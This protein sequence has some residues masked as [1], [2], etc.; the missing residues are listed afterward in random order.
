MQDLRKVVAAT[1]FSETS[2][3]AAL[4]AGMIAARHGVEGNLLHVIEPGLIE[5]LRSY[6]D[7]PPLLEKVREQAIALLQSL[8]E[9]VARETQGRLQPTFREGRVLDEVLAASGDGALL[10]LGSRGL[11][12]IH[13]YFL[14]STARNLLYRQSGPVLV[15]KGPARE[16][17]RNVL[18]ATDFSSH[19]AAALQRAHRLFPDARLQAVHVV[20]DMV[21][22]RM[23]YAGVDE[24]V[25]AEYRDKAK[26]R[27]KMD[28]MDFLVKCGVNDAVSDTKVLS[29]NPV[30]A[31][32]SLASDNEADLVVVG[33]QGRSGLGDM[34]MGGVTQH[35]LQSD[36]FDVLVE[37]L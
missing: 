26:A 30:S 35:L 17:Y 31:L 15:V 5:F 14:G 20:A 11:R 16:E 32:T 18:V 27:A 4:R 21:D 3:W 22:N 19:S 8:S 1:D 34:V 37:C 6:S 36:G 2:E 10:V 29:G 23:S 28:L 25:L 9:R 13:D 7:E 33:K 12:G 24:S